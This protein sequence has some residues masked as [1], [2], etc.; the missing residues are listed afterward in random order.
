[1]T[2]R[3]K[4]FIFGLVLLV[5]GVVLAGLGAY[6]ASKGTPAPL[7][8]QPQN[9]SVTLMLSPYLAWIGLASAV[10]GLIKLIFET[11]KAIRDFF[12]HSAPSKP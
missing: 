11:L 7:P 9:P 4:G 2:R 5:F 12:A 1:L 3:T 6:V 10:V 8:G